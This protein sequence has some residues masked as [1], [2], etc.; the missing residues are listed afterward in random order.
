MTNEKQVSE[1]NKAVLVVGAGISGMQSA[2]L[3]AEAGYPVHLLDAAPAIGGAF[4]LLDRTFPTDSCG[5]CHMLPGRAA[6]CPT[7][8]CDLHPNIDILPYAE[9]IGLEGEPGAF[10]VRVRHKPRYVSVERCID[11]ARC[12]GVCPEERS[13]QYEGT[14]H[15]ERAIYRPPLRG[16]PGTYVIDMDVCTRCGKCIE[17]C[18]TDAIDLDMAPVESTLQVGAVILSPGFEPFD[19]RLKGEFGFG[20]YDNVLSS[21]QL[22]RMISFAGST[23]AHVLRPSDGA[24]P[25]RVAFIHCVGSRDVSIGKGYCSSVCCMY[26]AKQVKVLKSLEPDVDVTVF[27]MDI[28]AHGKDFD[29]YFDQVEALPGVT[30]RRSMVSAVHQLQQSRNLLLT[31]VAEDGSPVEAEFD[32]V[33]LVVG[34][35]APEGVQALGE[36][37]GVALNEYG[38]GRT[39]YFAPDRSSRPGIFLAGSFR[40]PKDI[41]ETVV[42][43]S[44]VAGSAARLLNGGSQSPL[45]SPE[46]EERDVSEEWPR[47]GVF[48]GDCA[49]TLAETVDLEA[50]AAHA[51]GLRHVALAQ[52]VADGFAAAGLAAVART[53]QEEKI[54]R[55]VVA[56]PVDLR[57]SDALRAMMAEAALNANLLEVVNLGGEVAWPHAGNG[58]ATTKAMR[59]VEMAV[60][61][62]IYRQPFRPPAEPLDQRVLVIGGGLAGM[63]AALA[64]AEMGHPVDLVERDDVLGGQLRH[65][66]FVLGGSDPQA[67]LT[68]LLEQVRDQPRIRVRLQTAVQGVTGRLGQ[69]Q[70]ALAPVDGEPEEETYGAV[71]VATGGRE[72][73]PAE[74][75]YGQDE[76]VLTQREL[77]QRMADLDPQSIV[78][79][80]CVGSREPERPYCSRICCTKAVTNA[81]AV[82]ERNPAARVYVLYREIRT[83]GFREDAYRQAREKG[84]IFMRYDLDHKPEVEALEEGLRVRL[85]EPISGR[86][87]TLLSDLVVLSNGIAAND[88]RALAESMGLELDDYGFFREEHVKMRPLDLGQRGIFVAG[89]A[90]SPRAADETIAMAQGAAMRAVCLLAPARVEAQRTVARVNPRLCSTCGLCVEA[91]PYGARRLGPDDAYAEVLETVCQGCGVC[92]MVCPNGAT[93]QVGFAMRRVYD[94]LDAAVS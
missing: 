25:R 79:I 41:P 16:V 81:L 88:N 3:L 35:G 78:M 58:A 75:L 12:A 91:C 56:G 61:G 77:E 31:Y 71:I 59:L 92:L 80:Q 57:L 34:F 40:E 43:A 19:A 36:T 15:M 55:V 45:A 42:E 22:E 65:L 50:V 51:R 54:N 37:L 62:A 60:A 74:Y 90:H 44:A 20:H 21:V 73:T 23:S 18:P 72:V 63:T 38:F 6:Y 14:L 30:Y 52:I 94:M 82:K 26:A 76:R 8:E 69:F 46:A 49:G 33:V 11:C 28:R 86:K 29:A 84:V 87:V 53:V 89:L 48:I 24:T 66:R 2:L 67:A 10:T 32:M 83:Y 93:E 39:G 64:A 13:S 47:V 68:A 7:I 70:A 5:I 4:H 85:V 27:F 17:V 9:V 1:Q